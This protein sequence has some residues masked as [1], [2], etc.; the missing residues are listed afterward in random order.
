MLLNYAG[1]AGE[2]VLTGSL[3]VFKS[4]GGYIWLIFYWHTNKVAKL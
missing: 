2:S 3:N 1:D 4:E